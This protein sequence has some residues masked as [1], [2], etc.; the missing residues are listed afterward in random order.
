MPIK[1]TKS[2]IKPTIKPALL[3]PYATNRCNTT[4]RRSCNRI[5]TFACNLERTM[6]DWMSNGI[7]FCCCVA[8][9]PP[10]P[11]NVIGFFFCDS[12]PSFDWARNA[13]GNYSE[14]RVREN[15]MSISTHTVVVTSRSSY[16]APL[17][18]QRRQ[19]QRDDRRQRIRNKIV[20]LE[21]K[22]IDKRL[23]VNDAD[24]GIVVQTVRANG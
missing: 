19:Q 6:F 21:R 10:P 1:Q 23:R 12:I 13:N 17:R 2:T 24:V 16:D 5:E 7:E 3:S 22:K 8:S 9:P 4:R 18:A 15:N 20:E 11:L 14:R